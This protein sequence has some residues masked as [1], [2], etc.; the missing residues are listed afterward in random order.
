MLQE[1]ISDAFSL[2]T[3]ECLEKNSIGGVGSAV[4][5]VDV[6]RG[7]INEVPKRWIQYLVGRLRVELPCSSS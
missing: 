2:I 5:F 3:S 7:V 1:N 4:K 6:A